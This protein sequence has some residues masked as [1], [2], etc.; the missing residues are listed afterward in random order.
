MINKYM[1][2]KFRHIIVS[3][4]I[5]IATVGF[6][7]SEQSLYTPQINGTIRAK[8]EYLTTENEG[9]FQVRNTRVSVTGKI[10]PIIS[11]KAEVDLSVEGKISMLDAFVRLEPNRWSFTLGQMRVPF[12]L[13]VHRAPHQMYFANR[14]FLAKQV[15]N[16]RD[17]GFAMS[18]SPIKTMPWT[19]QG[20]IFNGSGIVNQ[21]NFWTKRFNFS[22]KTQATVASNYTVQMGFQRNK[23]NDVGIVMWNAGAFFQDS[24][25]HIEGEYLRKNYSHGA[26]QGVNAVNAFAAYSF[27]MKEILSSISVLGRYD[28]LSNHSNGIKDSSG[29]LVIDDPERHRITGGVTLRAGKGS[30]FAELRF[31]YEKY[32][33]PSTAIVGISDQDKVIVEI[34][35]RF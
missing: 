1:K 16:I 33:Y 5:T 4:A 19:I 9:R 8:Y 22:I 7:Q 26:F 6:A 18:V 32:F 31:N 3:A 2:L 14:S 24:R 28:Y 34:M 11:Y 30:R 29:I 25:W 27:P 17:V 10:M 13:D 35:C 20:G 15:A 21:K 23:P 12:T